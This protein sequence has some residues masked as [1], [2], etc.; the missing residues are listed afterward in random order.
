M[1]KPNNACLNILYLNARSIL[2]K[3]DELRVL[4]VV[5][6]YDI[7]RVVESWLSND[8]VNSELFIPGYT[9][10]RKDRN[11]HGGGIIVFVRNSLPCIV[12]PF[13][14]FTSLHSQLEFLPLCIE[15]CEHKFCISVFIDH[16][17][18][19]YLI[20]MLLSHLIL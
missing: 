11:R 17:L 7:V 5:N 13:Q 12:L 15:F 19:M 8:I 14:N 6:S 9:I 20:L 18:L 1:S 4:C 16:L 10:V 3:L 2:P